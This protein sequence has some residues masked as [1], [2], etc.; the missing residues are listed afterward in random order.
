MVTLF[1]S[2]VHTVSTVGEAEYERI[3]FDA[4]SEEGVRILAFR[5]FYSHGVAGGGVDGD[6][7]AAVWGRTDR[8][9]EGDNVGDWATV[10][11]NLDFAEIMAD[12]G[13]Y[14][15]EGSALRTEFVTAVGEWGQITPG[16][17]LWRK[18][19][20]DLV[21]ARDLQVGFVGTAALAHG[22]AIAFEYVKLSGLDSARLLARRR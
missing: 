1:R 14:F 7:G 20:F 22:V 3:D 19:P 5:W 2:I 12:E 11:E 17:A 13:T 6:E 9:H 21:I 8:L 18:I 10:G 16:N 4:S 15:A